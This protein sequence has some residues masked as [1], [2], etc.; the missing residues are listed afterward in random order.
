MLV[1]VLFDTT[2]NE[3]SGLNTL[4]NKVIKSKKKKQV[5][6]VMTVLDLHWVDS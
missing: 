4:Q 2:Y 1:F 5:N 6:T 3:V